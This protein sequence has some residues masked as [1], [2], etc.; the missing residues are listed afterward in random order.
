MIF[1]NFQ[2]ERQN[3]R[4]RC[5]STE[6]CIAD[7]RSLRALKSNN[8][9]LH[10]RLLK[11]KEDGDV[12]LDNVRKEC[13][14]N[15]T[16]LHSQHNDN[17]HDVQ[18]AWMATVKETQDQ[19]QNKTIEQVSNTLNTHFSDIIQE[20]RL[21]LTKCQNQNSKLSGLLDSCVVNA[22]HNITKMQ[23]SHDGHSQFLRKINAEQRQELIRYINAGH[24]CAKEKETIKNGHNECK[25]ENESYF[26]KITSCQA[27][28]IDHKKN[29][30]SLAGPTAVTAGAVAMW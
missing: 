12:K 7:L 18:K 1:I 5:S 30:S 22:K 26:K 27:N 20:K 11:Q 28:F 17:L 25:L 21:D 16:S 23:V 13:T 19:C 3:F 24:V 6:L 8:A 9:E 4:R 2:V 14:A 29:T 10:R 15:T